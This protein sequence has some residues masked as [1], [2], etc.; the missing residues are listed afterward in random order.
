MPIERLDYADGGWCEQEYVDG[1]LHGRWTVYFATGRK[2][3]ERD[4]QRGRKEGY[5]RTWDESGNL[6]EERH[7]HLGC[8]HGWWRRWDDN[9][10]EEVIGEFQLGIEL[11]SEKWLAWPHSNWERILPYVRWEP[12]QFR[13]QLKAVERKLAL[14]SS[15]LT[16]DESCPFRD[17]FG[18][19]YFSYV[20]LVGAE[21]DWPTHEGVPLIP[22]VQ[23]DC[24]AIPRL[25]HFLTGV[26]YLTMFARSDPQEF[27][28]LVI[29]TYRTG[30]TLRHILPPPGAIVEQP[31]FM[32]ILPAEATY[33][34]DNDLPRGLRALLEDEQPDSPILKETSGRFSS[35]FGG[36]PAWLQES[37]VYSYGEFVLQLDR[38][39][40]ETLRGGASAI[41]YFFLNGSDWTWASE[42][43]SPLYHPSGPR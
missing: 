16:R 11:S 37:G 5:E 17:E 31:H 42:S 26:A 20:N 6:R 28:D 3:W 38:F 10:V 8:L 29:R 14:P 43:L 34:H 13:P 7:Y 41:H 35:R 40:V 39:D 4:Y 1:K 9:G 36:W 2:S 25:P 21:E 24:R 15:C 27:S 18:A 22:L 12:E 30:E 33:P 32:K 23:I 19:S